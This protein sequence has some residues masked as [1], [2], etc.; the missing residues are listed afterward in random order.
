M[1]T[2]FDD[3]LVDEPVANANAFDDLLMDE[4]PKEKSFFGLGDTASALAEIPSELYQGIPIAFRRMRLGLQDPSS[5]SPEDAAAFEAESQRQAVLQQEQEAREARGENTS[6]GDAFRGAVRSLPFSVSTMVPSIAAGAGTG[7]A[8]GAVF[9][10]SELVTVPVGAIAGT[11]AGMLASGTAAYRMAGQQFLD[12]SIR[13]LQDKAKSE[14][15]TLSKEELDNAYEVLLPIAEN[16]GLWEAGPEAVGNAVTAGAGKFIFGFGKDLAAD[17]VKRTLGKKIAAAVGA[18]GVEVGGET[19][20]AMNQGPD[21]AKAQQFI[22]T[23]STEGALDEYQGL[24]GFGKA[25]EEVGPTVLATQALFGGTGGG[26]KLGEM[27]LKKLI[28]KQNTQDPF[29][30][31]APITEDDTSAED[32]TLDE[33]T[34]LEPPAPVIPAPEDAG[35][36]QESTQMDQ[37]IADDDPISLQKQWQSLEDR[38]IRAI[39]FGA[40]ERLP[41]IRYEQARIARKITGE[42]KSPEEVEKRQEAEIKEAAN[43]KIDAVAPVIT[44]DLVANKSPLTAVA[45]NRALNDSN[46]AAEVQK[47]REA[48]I[49]AAKLIQAAQEQAAT[50]TQTQ[51]TPPNEES[52]LLPQANDETQ[53]DGIQ[54]T[55]V[56]GQEVVPPETQ[57]ADELDPFES[58]LPETITANVPPATSP[59][60]TTGTQDPF[61]DAPTQ[62]E[63]V[64]TQREATVPASGGTVVDVAPDEVTSKTSLTES[65]VGDTGG[66]ME[67]KRAKAGGEY[68][69]NGE[70]YSGGAFIA[71]TDMPKKVKEKISRASRGAEQVEPGYGAN[72]RQDI[73]AGKLPIVARIMGTFIGPD[74]SVNETYIERNG[75]DKETADQVR[76]AA[77]RYRNGERLLDVTEFPLLANFTD[78]ARLIDSELPV[79]GDLLSK[80]PEDVRATLIQASKV[81]TTNRTNNNDQDNGESGANA[82][83]DTGNAQAGNDGGWSGA[84]GDGPTTGTPARSGGGQSTSSSKATSQSNGD[85]GTSTATGGVGAVQEVTQ[86]STP[87]TQESWEQS[88]EFQ[89]AEEAANRGDMDEA[90]RIEAAWNERNLAPTPGPQVTPVP[91]KQPTKKQE[92]P[93]TVAP[94]RESETGVTISP[95]SS[96]RTQ[97]RGRPTTTSVDAAESTKTDTKSNGGKPEGSREQKRLEK[98]LEKV[99]SDILDAEADGDERGADGLRAA[100]LRIERQL[101]ELTQSIPVSTIKQG[102]TIRFKQ[103]GQT[104]SGTY[105]GP[106]NQSGRQVYEVQVA[107]EPRSRRVTAQSINGSNDAQL[108]GTKFSRINNEQGTRLNGPEANMA[109]ADNQSAGDGIQER[110]GRD[111]ETVSEG[112]NSERS[113]RILEGARGVVWDKLSNSEKQKE[114]TDFARSVIRD[115]HLRNTSPNWDILLTDIPSD[116]PNARI[117]SVSDGKTIVTINAT[118][119]SSMPASMAPD[120]ESAFAFAYDTMQEEY[121]HAMHLATMAKSWRN[122]GSKQSVDAY[123]I[124]R[125][126]KAYSEALY[127]ALA[128]KRSGNTD[129]AL[130][131]EKGIIDAFNLYS[132]GAK[133]VTS[134]EQFDDYVDR[135]II[136]QLQFYGE[137]VRQ[138]S[139]LNRQDFTTETGWLKFKNM[140]LGWF[141]DAINSLKAVLP[142][143]RNGDLGPII[144]QD[145][146]E[147]ESMMRDYRDGKPM[148]K[149]SRQRTTRP[150][151]QGLERKVAEEHLKKLGVPSSKV[152]IIDE[153]SIQIKGR[154]DPDG[155]IALNIAYLDSVEEINDTLMNHEAIHDAVETDK[156]VKQ[157]AIELLDAL[158]DDEMSI[159]NEQIRGYSENEKQDERIVEAVRLMTSRR[160]DLRTKWARFVEAVSLAI[161]KFLGIKGPY[162]DKQVAELV[163]ARILARGEARVLKGKMGGRDK[164]SGNMYSL[165]TQVESDNLPDKDLIRG[166]AEARASRAAKEVEFEDD[167]DRQ[168]VFG[169]QIGP[170]RIKQTMQEAEAAAQEVFNGSE[171]PLTNEG[172]KQWMKTM[173][174]FSVNNPES[175]NRVVE[176]RN[177]SNSMAPTALQ[178]ELGIYAERVTAATNDP[179]LFKTFINEVNDLVAVVGGV[180]DSARALVARRWSPL[181]ERWGAAAKTLAEVKKNGPPDVDT[182]SD[183]SANAANQEMTDALDDNPD[184]TAAI[185]AMD[186]AEATAERILTRVSEQYAD[187]PLAEKVKKGEDPLRALYR[188][189]LDGKLTQDQF[190][191]RATQILA[192]VDEAKL[193]EL[194]EAET[195][196][197]KDT[198][199]K[200]EADWASGVAQRLWNA[201]SMERD[202]AA[203]LQAIKDAESAAKK[204]ARQDAAAQAQIDAANNRASQLLF[205]VEKRMRQ[206]GIQP[207]TQEQ[208]DTFRKA[209]QDQVRKPVSFDAFFKRVEAL[210]IGEDVANRAFRTAARERLDVERMASFK[211]KQSFLEQD[212]KA[213][214]KL[215]SQVKGDVKWSDFF[216]N[217]SR[218]SQ[219]ERQRRIYTQILKHDNLRNLSQAER[220]QLTREL[221]KAWARA[222]KKVFLREFEKKIPLKNPKLKKQLAAQAP[223]LLKAI[224]LGTFDSQAYRKEISKTYGLKDLSDADLVKVIKLGAEIQDARGESLAQRKKIEELANLVSGVTNI[225]KSHILA[226]YYIS[227][228][229]ASGRTGVGAMFS[230]LEVAI[231]AVVGVTMTSWKSPTQAMAGLNAAFKA[232]PRGVLEGLSHFRTG[233]KTGTL[234]ATD[235]FNQWLKG[236]GYSPVSI[237]ELLWKEKNPVK[238]FAGLVIMASERMLTGIDLM[239][240]STLHEA[241]MIWSNSITE[242]K[243]S[244]GNTVSLRNPTAADKERMRRQV[245]AEWF[246]GIEPPKTLENLAKINAGMRDQ[247]ERFYIDEDPSAG[248]ELV[249]GG[250]RT[251]SGPSF[252]G[253]VTGTVGFLIKRVNGLFADTGEAFEK[254][255]KKNNISDTERNIASLGVGLFALAKSF[256]GLQFVSFFGKLVNRNLQFVPGSAIFPI[257]PKWIYGENISEYERRS[258]Q[259]KN[260]L[261]LVLITSVLAYIMGDDDDEDDTFGLEGDWSSLSGEQ[262]DAKRTAKALPSSIWYRDENGQKVYLSFANSSLS[263]VFSA[264]ANLREIKVNNPEKWKETSDAAIAAEGIVGAVKSVFNTSAMGRLAELLGGSPFS[265]STP[266]AGAEKLASNVATFA[267][268]FVPSVIRE[269]DFMQDPSYY[270]PKTLAERAVSVIPFLRRQVAESQGSLG[271]LGTPA[272]INRSPTSRVYSSGADTEAEKIL[273]RMADEGLYLPLPDDRKG[274]DYVSPVSGRK[275]QMT[276]PQIMEYVK[277]TGEAYQ[278]LILREGESLMTMDRDKAKERISK[279]ASKIKSRAARMSM[280]IQ[281]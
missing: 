274:K 24:E 228:I 221:D 238:K 13:G 56:Q 234:L 207:M 211:K 25:L 144:Q 8:V 195:L 149:Y 232:F 265:K 63:E 260:A 224:N 226:S 148:A 6:V 123:I 75:F 64:S 255:A 99:D 5:Y 198:T 11:A 273:A 98:A 164:F 281:E 21:Q 122:S 28:G 190:I 160:P 191:N 236:D 50:E 72:K 67:Q 230:I 215:L 185:E 115:L 60:D 85:V 26:V 267:G 36:E 157:R 243:D 120:A 239:L 41:A 247:I 93:A 154:Y 280:G 203:Q 3:L 94:S 155:G 110:G 227:S 141:N 196:N 186:Q 258:I 146:K 47:A 259:T 45:M 129:L 103:E 137:F 46:D 253:E 77:K 173:D 9:P 114:V 20:T 12:D 140:V 189:L 88:P 145:I 134:I 131:I 34:A 176:L 193:K 61:E 151:T 217:N 150:K 89:A 197:E 246:G 84:A 153:P 240:S 124:Q 116:R 268:G 33:A 35:Q 180:S 142:L 220:L 147:L 111:N 136:N 222:R 262:R 22:E 14:G 175:V 65:Q 71:T 219:K 178:T 204:K 59:T 15:K 192:G 250:R 152:Y 213:L 139:Q 271:V 23:G 97:K 106:V 133:P 277:L 251:A 55:D 29:N 275:I 225:P 62:G 194:Y 83:S 183:E 38:A 237:G 135:G 138:L 263:W 48:E 212:S 205:E 235:S 278:R 78:A 170:E 52:I 177:K 241:A 31:E 249:K 49:E 43:Q 7:A 37:V 248:L 159:I 214:A 209:F 42:T 16:T 216:T 161:K 167:I 82:K 76:E 4:P 261:G 119:A 39:E 272:Q 206:S 81:K 104:L 252:Q 107:G 223:A 1:P 128:A 118:T 162:L 87:P 79:P 108:E 32:L 100:K 27:G 184:E 73:P 51:E 69:P 19:I 210:K 70:W 96:P 201:G 90:E 18:T 266:G 169:Q 171:V 188:E 168:Q 17:V 181:T 2:A 53:A 218:I 113:N 117:T 245:I 132:G 166:Y 158:T 102:D 44:Q 121:I 276:K 187:A 86:P 256:A 163:A 264:A 80:M 156:K 58:P 125:S 105:V 143:A 95:K 92:T 233:D 182:T 112:D 66:G 165:P 68:G 199:T 269:L 30:P 244:K 174:D 279:A 257:F 130:K 229:L 202:A 270:E 172:L 74:G 101:E 109:G 242:F 208:K 91:K 127:A 231:E 179:T 126:K 57:V 254:Y 200:L 10:P 54:A 40:T